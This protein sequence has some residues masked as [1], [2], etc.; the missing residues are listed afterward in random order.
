MT[1]LNRAGSRL[2][3]SLLYSSAK[4]LGLR[5]GMPVI[6]MYPIISASAP[7]TISDAAAHKRR[8]RNEPGY[9]AAFL[10]NKRA[11]FIAPASCFSAENSA[12]DQ[13]DEHKQHHAGGDER[14]AMKIRR[15]SPFP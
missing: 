3:L 8:T 11:R 10:R 9:R 13:Q 7:A 15:V 1:V 12:V 5:L 14:L 4:R 2:T 6:R